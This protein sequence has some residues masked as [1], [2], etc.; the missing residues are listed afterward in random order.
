MNKGRKTPSTPRRKV[1]ASL[2]VSAARFF[3]CVCAI[4]S[5]ATF[6]RAQ[7]SDSDEEGQLRFRFVGPRV[8]NRI[9]AVAGIAGDASTYYAGAASGGVWKSTDGGNDWKP[10]FDKEPAAAIGALAVAPSAPTTVWAGTGEAWA[11]RD[12]DV[13]GNGIYKSTD[14]GKTWTNMGLPES[15]RIGRIVVHPS[16]ADIVFACVLGRT[17]GPQQERGVYRTTDGGQHWERVLFAGENVGCS[18]LAMDPHNPHTLF[19][20]TWQ[21][22]MHTYGEFSGGP[23]SGVY[24]SHDG[25]TKWTHIEEHGL[26]KSPVGKIDVAVAPSNSNRVYALIQTKDQGSL[27]RSD[28]AGEHWKVVNYQRALIGRAGYYI[29]VAVSPDNDN[30]VY[31]ANSSFH[32]S[33]DGG[34]NFE[35]VPWG[36]DTHDIWIDPTN[37]DRFVITDDG[38]MHITTVH[39]RGFH[40]VTLPI[41]QMYHVDVDNQ[42]PYYF[43]SN[44]QD[45]GNMRGPSMPIGFNETG[46]DHAMGGCES[47]FTI[48]DW[49]DPN[50]VWATCYG[51]KVTRWDARTKHARSVSPWMITLDSPP[52]DVKYRCHWTAP[53]A[54]D[55]FD[56]NTVYYGCQVIFKTSDG[57]QSWSVISPDLST[58]DPSRIISSGGLVGD[59]LGQ[60]YGEVV[61]AIAPSKVKKGLIWAGT[62]DGQVWHTDDNGQWIN[63]TKNIP[64]LPA[65]GTVTSIAPSVF[66]AGTAY[67]S[68][69]LH[70]MDNRDPFIYKT[71]DLGKSWKLIT[72]NLPKDE[73][74]YVRTIAEDPNCAGLLFAGTGNDLFYSLDDG[75]HWTALDSGLPHAPVSW[76]VVQ[77]EFH[78]LVIS[79]YGRGLYILDDISPLEQM[80]KHPSDASVTLFEPRHSYRFTRGGEALLTF[81]VKAAP[82]KS[83]EIEI[84]DSEGKVIRKLETKPKAG[85]NRVKWDLRYDSPRLIALRTVA[86][87]NPHIWDEPRFRDSDSRP[88]THWGTKPAEVGPIVAPGKYT[89]RLKVDD[90]TY[91]TTSTVLPD[92][93][94]GE[95]E[96]D[97]D[98]S[99]KTLL[100]IRD[101]IS[102]VSD[103][104]NQIEWIR[105]Q[106]EVIQAML[107]PPKKKE[108]GEGPHSDEEDYYE[109]PGGAPAPPAKLS[110]AETKRKADLLKASDDFGKKLEAIED[111]LV[112]RA[113]L[114]SDD[115]YF[116]EPYQVYLNLIWLNAAVGTGG[117]DVAGGADFAPTG[118]ETELLKTFETQMAAVDA[119]YQNFMKVDL[120]A[121]N[122]LLSNNNSVTLVTGPN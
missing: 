41:G 21:V 75:G 47:G 103:T 90:Q 16:N 108:A 113:L 89:V 96:K 102:H 115:K 14:A 78:D 107:R 106:L 97:I 30:E 111:R 116:V 31:I 88:I 81:A 64:G 80:A 32:R 85:M 104:V 25:G 82:K 50:I 8:G 13:M 35:E 3:V 67:I 37:S 119:D 94:T 20:G 117:G 112:S 56:H 11:I 92:P 87:D 34:E 110:E 60:F 101:D 73:L 23:G 86:P 44:M 19:A 59:N 52:N 57:G 74:S 51:N 36:G 4:V 83:A 79:T 65:W 76:A 18:G 26:P 17:T 68:V 1:K 69:D 33:L 118:S 39:G 24:V 122:Q 48:P 100:R 22:E 29:R 42:I 5:V 98:L 99:V 58:H 66:D 121:F 45:D 2:A 71:S 40:H 7:Q 120:A 91:T 28:D 38:G 49:S 105:K 77:K 72:S 55:P 6:A 63:V 70:L 27:W 62:N 9:S 114:N 53:L 95:P 43:Y 15:G 54:I 10:I 46:W 12:S 84:S 109:G 61:F 93:R